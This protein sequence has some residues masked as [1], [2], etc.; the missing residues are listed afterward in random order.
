MISTRSLWLFQN[1]ASIWTH[2]ANVWVIPIYIY[3]YNY[4][5]TIHAMITE[6]TQRLWRN[7]LGQIGFTLWLVSCW[8][9]PENI[10]L[11]NADLLWIGPSGTFIQSKCIH[12]QAKIVFGKVWKCRPC[13]SVF[14]VFVFVLWWRHQM[15]AFPRFLPFVRGIH[16]SPM[17]SPHKG[18]WR[19]DLMFCLICAWKND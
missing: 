14:I 8:A 17:N 3:I 5:W 18:Q 7:K 2:A 11:T 13:C 15:E 1:R 10:T 12:F 6:N 16:R 4:M 19:G 9:L